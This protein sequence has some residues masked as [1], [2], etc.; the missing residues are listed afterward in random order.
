MIPICKL[1]TALGVFAY[2]AQ[3]RLGGPVMQRCATAALAL[4]VMLFFVSAPASVQTTA[5]TDEGSSRDQKGGRKD[6]C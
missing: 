5:G 4:L 1:N 2:K 6:H 3:S